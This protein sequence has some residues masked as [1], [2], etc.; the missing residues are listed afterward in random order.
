MP[1]VLRENNLSV[2]IYL[3]PKEH[4]PA[5]VHVDNGQG[6]VVVIRLG[7][8]RQVPTLHLVYGM[9][10]QEI[11]RAFRLVEKNV[12]KLRSAWEDFHGNA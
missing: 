10:Y 3:P 6:G 5:H 7:T 12:G 4:A 11:V 1:T 2:R 8:G 9:K